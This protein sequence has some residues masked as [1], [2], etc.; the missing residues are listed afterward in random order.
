MTN[1]FQIQVSNIELSI[2]MRCMYSYQLE[3]DELYVS[4][5]VKLAG[6]MKEAR[7]SSEKLAIEFMRKCIPIFKKRYGKEANLSISR[8]QS[9]SKDIR[10]L[11]RIDNDTKIVKA[12]L[13]QNNMAPNKKVNLDC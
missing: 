2:N 5:H 9:N 4:P 1:W 7:I 10:L 11:N 6:D 3:K 13:L 12:R 8:C